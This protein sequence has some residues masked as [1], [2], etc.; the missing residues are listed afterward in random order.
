MKPIALST[1][2]KCVQCIKCLKLCPVDA[3]SIVN[4]QV[5]INAEKCIY[6]GVCI[7]ECSSRVLKVKNA[8]IS[9]TLHLHDYNVILIPTSL[10]SDMKSYDEFEKFNAAILKLGFDEIVQYSDI[11]GFLYKKA[12]QESQERQGIWLMPFCPTINRLIEK[13][14]PT[15]YDRLLPY[16]YPVEIAARRVRK[17]LKDKNI[18]IY[19]LCECV[20]KMTLA[21]YPFGNENSEIDYAV[22]I[23]HIFPKINK[24][25]NEDRHKVTMNKYG[26]KSNVEDLF[27]NRSLSVLSIEGLNQAKNLLE[28]L[29]FD[30][31]NHVD[32]I[33]MYACYQGCIG[34]YYLWSNPYEGCYNI[35]SMMEHYSNE[36]ILLNEDEYIISRKFD[37]QEM[38]SIKEK[39]ARFMKVNEILEQLPQ[40]DCGA[41]GFANC[42]TL[43]QGVVDG[44]VSIDICR[45]KKGENI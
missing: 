12:I 1:Q 11:E 7:K 19:S 27:G 9:D 28:L 25:K 21:K 29:E 31:I 37:K 32:L 35:E 26:V 2:I 40:F 34:G 39:M 16:D 38:E 5:H 4:H 43:A 30:R 33:A 6:C 18:A 14:Y 20:A 42:R 41:C 22:T 24:Y 3:I 23:S 15:L 8:H 45:V 10:L 17:R 44:K 13:N 36:I